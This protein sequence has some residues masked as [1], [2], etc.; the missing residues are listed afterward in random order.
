MNRKDF[1]LFCER[2][3]VGVCL[4]FIT[5]ISKAQSLDLKFEHLTSENGLPQNATFGIA[6]DKFGFMWFGTWSGLCR[7]D[8]YRFKIYRYQPGKPR[9][10][11]SS[12]IMGIYKDG[13]QRLWVQ[14]YN[15]SIICRYN[16]ITDDFDRIPLKKVPQSIWRNLNWITHRTNM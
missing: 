15:D 7:Y 11:I 1:K 5:G 9:S 3:L 13:A 6:K 16:Y 10:I 4:F 12:R 8:G 14:T 2:V